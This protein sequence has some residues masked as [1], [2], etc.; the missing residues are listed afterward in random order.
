MI[1]LIKREKVELE[2]SRTIVRILVPRDTARKLQQ[3]LH[4]PDYG[5]VSS[6]GRDTLLGC[7]LSIDVEQADEYC[8]EDVHGRKISGS[9]S[10]MAH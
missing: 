3:E 10:F 9:G 5:P 4:G 6:N 8:F 7:G 1:D 2:K